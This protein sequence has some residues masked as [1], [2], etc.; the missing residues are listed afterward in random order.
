[1][2]PGDGVGTDEPLV[3]GICPGQRRPDQGLRW[4]AA[5][6]AGAVLMPQPA[7]LVVILDPRRRGDRSHARAE[8]IV[9]PVRAGLTGDVT[10]IEGDGDRQ[11]IEERDHPE[12]D[13]CHSVECRYCLVDIL[14]R[15]MRANRERTRSAAPSIVDPEQVIVVDPGCGGLV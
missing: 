11:R 3:A 4:R 14:S 9:A 12:V 10:G 2:M 15:D 6:I 1:Y 7:F 5:E 13:V 8:R